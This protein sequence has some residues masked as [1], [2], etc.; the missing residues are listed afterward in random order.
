MRDRSRRIAGP[1]G[2]FELGS[3]ASDVMVAVAQSVLLSPPCH[4][5]FRVDQMKSRPTSAQ[6]PRLPRAALA[7][8][9]FVRIGI[10]A[11]LRSGAQPSVPM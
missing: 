3:G 9:D 4:R 11:S 7:G 6:P 2:D 8:A 1:V 10:R 5:P